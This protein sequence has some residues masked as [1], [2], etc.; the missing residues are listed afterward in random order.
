MKRTKG[1]LVLALMFIYAIG[2]ALLGFIVL[3]TENIEIVKLI[4]IT[5]FVALIPCY[6]TIWYIERKVKK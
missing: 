6:I 4:F 2:Y 5:M 1:N 3:N